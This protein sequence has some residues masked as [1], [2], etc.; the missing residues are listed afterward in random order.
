M[1]SPLRKED[2]PSKILKISDI[3]IE[4]DKDFSYL[5]AD[6]ACGDIVKKYKISTREIRANELLLTDQEETE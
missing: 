6:I 3:R 5:C 1:E 4:S 2:T